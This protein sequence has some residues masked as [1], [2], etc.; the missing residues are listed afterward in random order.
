M[1][2]RVTTASALVALLAVLASS[3]ALIG[4]GSTY[5]VGAVFE[6]AVNLYPGSPVRA[7]GI[8]VGS[9]T[10]VENRDGVVHV[11][12]AL[13]EGTELPA[14]ARAVVVPVT[15]LGERYVQ[16]SPVYEG[17]P[18]LEDGDVIPQSRTQVPFE[19][20]ELLRGLDG[21]L[22]QIDPER[23]GDLITNLADLLEGQGQ[24]LNDLIRNAS[25]TVD[26]LA[27]KGDELGAI[28]ES[29]AQLTTTLGGRTAAVQELIRSY[30]TVTGVL[31]GN[32]DDLNA[33]ITNLDRAAVELGGLLQRHRDP[34]RRDLGVLTTAGR[35]LERNI[36]RLELML[37][38]T[39]R[40]FAAAARAY[41]P[42]RNV[43]V[44]NNQAEPGLASDL[45]KARLRDRLAGL[46]RRIIVALGG[47]A[48]A[49]AAGLVAAD[50]ANASSPFWDAL[51]A[52]TPAPQPPAA[53]PPV[54]L[55]TGPPPVPDLPLPD[56]PTLVDGL[57]LL[58]TLINPDQLG[59]LQGLTPALIA[60]IDGLTDQQ[61]AA[62]AFLTPG[63]IA[64][65]R[66][67]PADQLGPTL[68][69]II[70]GQLDPAS[71]LDQPLLPPTGGGGGGGGGGTGAGL[72][73]GLGGLV[74]GGG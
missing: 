33:F 22:G 46:C 68:D 72:G 29:L 15:V 13:D 32:Q 25:G 49:G 71:L 37:E 2:R 17:G 48:A 51:F 54:D 55:P 40:L 11:T 66:D 44:L 57:D 35:T 9:I 61:L 14:D 20:D 69:Q 23:A 10:D 21:Y 60:A 26:L 73:G 34:L 30:D 53:E 64:A 43:L 7:L 18:K 3:C 70:A 59:S 58:A 52:D 74:G 16:L 47:P 63:Q 56:V 24:E 12:M 27:D 41:D 62:L 28:V 65:L 5:E 38:S 1:T 39:P 8:D 31:V 67:V 6:R 42:E 36:D 45:Y 4:R 50:C 19:I